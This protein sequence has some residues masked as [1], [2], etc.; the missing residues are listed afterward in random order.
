MSKKR[1]D[2]IVSWAANQVLRL[3]SKEYRAY[4]AVLVN[5]GK[6]RLDA[7]LELEQ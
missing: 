3:A 5:L 1:W 6:Q 4:V 2:T 7:L